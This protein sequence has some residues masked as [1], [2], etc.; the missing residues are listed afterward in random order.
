MERRTTEKVDIDPDLIQS[1]DY[2]AVMRLDGLD[3][4]IMYGTGSHSGHSVMALRFEDGLHI[5]E[6]QDAWY[7]PTHGI[8]RT[9]WDKWLKQAENA[10]FHVTWMPLSDSMRAKFNETAARE[11]FFN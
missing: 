7:W 2:I 4:I 3:Q 9:P 5:V 8:Q 10:D 1:G 6:S 11:Y